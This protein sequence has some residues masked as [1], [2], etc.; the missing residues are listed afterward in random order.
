MSELPPNHFIPARG[1]RLACMAW[2]LAGGAA[3]AQTASLPSDKPPQRVLVTGSAIDDRFGENAR[4]PSSTTTISGKKLEAE[5]AENLIQILKA[6]PGVTIDTSG[7]DELKIKLRG[8]ENQR[9]MGEKPG[10]AIVIDGVPVFERT[11]KVNINL[12]NIQSIKVIK[13]G[14]SYLFGE[15]AL[16]GAVVITTK[17]GAGNAGVALELDGG[18]D[19]YRRML[20]RAGLEG[21]SFTGHVQASRREA[22]GYHFQS[23][24]QARA[25]TGN[26][27]WLLSKTSD[28]TL[29]LEREARYR[30]K[31]GTVTGVTQAMEDPRG[32]LGRD[33]ARHFDVDLLRTNL[34]Y[35]NDLSD[36][37]N[38]LAVV[39]QYADHTVYWSSPQRFS[40]TGAAVTSTDAYTTLND[41]HQRQRGAKTELRSTLG[42]LALLGGVE[43]KRN[44]YL[45]LTSAKVAYRNSPA[46]SVTPEGMVMGDDKTTEAGYALYGEA[47]WSP[48]AEWTGTANLRLDRMALEYDALPVAGNGNVA[49]AESKSFNTTSTRLGLAWTPQ[50]ETSVF[51]NISTG[52][53]IPTV[54]QLYRGS[55]SPTASVANNP[56][57]KPERSVNLEFGARQLFTLFGEPASVEGAVFQIDRKKF[58]LDTNGQY[59]NGNGANIGRYENIGGARSRGLELSLHAQ[60]VASL[61][62]D[63]AYTWLE[64]FFTQYEKFNLALGNPRGVLV[65]SSPA[66]PAANPNWNNCYKLVAY[67]NTGRDLPRVPHH[68]LNA[69]L[70]WQPTAGLRLWAEAD[71]RSTAWAD[72]INQER[73][74][75]RTVAN[76]MIEYSRKVEAM[77]GA[78]LSAFVRLDNAF[79]QRYFTIARGTNDSQS[80]ATNFRYDGQYNS[81]DMSITVDPG[82]VWRAGIALRF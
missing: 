66:C 7:G 80:Y 9:Y 71:Y 70:N 15:D 19:G 43:I 3:L 38:L 76:L 48:A 59:G 29:G 17:R 32:R 75:G 69:R 27:R 53:R 20:G 42:A 73:W 16:S 46:G 13:G 37:T 34:T 57:L 33:F 81:E 4:E 82:R 54:D 14:A 58:I 18:A 35:A 45:N 12:D 10:V 60:P 64:S 36:T 23:D 51:G 72:E 56:D 79:Q 30:D 52:F 61:N 49:I 50:R 26:L 41:Y 28:L 47:K 44:R 40:A 63:V 62:L 25:A 78:R 2:L 74:P 11:G 5:H 39:Y 1:Q 8:V 68:T 22:D 21:E 6:I 65:G 67:D 55:Q 31:H 24:Y 77:G